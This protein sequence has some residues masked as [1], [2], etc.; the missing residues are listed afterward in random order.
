MILISICV[1][2]VLSTLAVGGTHE[3]ELMMSVEKC[4]HC[5]CGGCVD[6]GQCKGV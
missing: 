1:I 2:I 5:S 3:K 4:D 6:K